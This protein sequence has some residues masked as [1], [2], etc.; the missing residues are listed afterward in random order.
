VFHSLQR[1]GV[2]VRPVDNYHLPEWIR[3]SVGLP[4]ENDRFLH[5]LLEAMP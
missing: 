3:V 4:H 1:R 2:I 5:T